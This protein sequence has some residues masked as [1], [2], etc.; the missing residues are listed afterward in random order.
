MDKG[1]IKLARSEE[2]E[3]LAMS[4]PSAF[5]LLALIA[6][7][8]R[9]KTQRTFDGRKMGEAYIGDFKSYGVSEQVYRTDKT[10]LESNGLI[11]TQPTNRGTIAKLVDSSI[12]DINIESTNDP[13]NGQLTNNQRTTNGQLTTNKNIKK[14]RNKDIKEKIY[15]KENLINFKKIYSL[16][17]EKINPNSKLTDSAK[18]KINSRLKTFSEDELLSAISNFSTNDWWME[19]NSQ[20]GIAWFFHSDDRI[21]Q[22]LNLMP[23]TPKDEQSNRQAFDKEA[24]QVIANYEAGHITKEQQYSQLKALRE[25]YFIY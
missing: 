7:R 22:F 24:D 16:Y 10:F 5:V 3:S 20:R 9:R 1:F 13:T 14:E 19:H 11:T 12:F 4:R 6:L 15:K 2:V 17:Q 8:A 18:I 23:T 21:D 25:K